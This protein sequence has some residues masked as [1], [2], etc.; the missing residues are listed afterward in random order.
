MLRRINNVSEKLSRH[1]NLGG[2]ERGGMGRDGERRG[3]EVT[4]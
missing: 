1:N 3:G 2:M 4:L